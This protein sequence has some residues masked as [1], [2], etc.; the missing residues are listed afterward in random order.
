MR[1]LVVNV[2][3]LVWGILY[4]LATNAAGAAG[5]VRREFT[6]TFLP[7]IGDISLL[8]CILILCVG[9]FSLGFVG[10]LMAV[11]K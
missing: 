4:L 9:V 1:K 5:Y 6:E 7:V 2:V 10:V 8:R 3:V 11:M